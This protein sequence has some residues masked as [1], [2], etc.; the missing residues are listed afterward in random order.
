MVIGTACYLPAVYEYKK[1]PER[2][3][4]E[5]IGAPDTA[6][7]VKVISIEIRSFDFLKRGYASVICLTGGDSFGVGIE[8]AAR[9]V[10]QDSRT[11]NARNCKEV[12]LLRA[13]AE[14]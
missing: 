3:I 4:L 13:A 8:V 5:R 1:M 12:S 9:K 2:S 10:A 14:H 7:V 6:F 11:A